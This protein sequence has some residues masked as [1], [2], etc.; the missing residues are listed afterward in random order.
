[1]TFHTSIT[2]EFCDEECNY[3]TP[4]FFI[5]GNLGR[6]YERHHFRPNT[7]LKDTGHVNNSVATSWQQPTIFLSMFDHFIGLVLERLRSIDFEET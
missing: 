1:M 5:C 7:V 6:I 2:S 4:L 3:R